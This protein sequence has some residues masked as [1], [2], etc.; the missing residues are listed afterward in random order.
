MR[1]NLGLV[2]SALAAR[3]TDVWSTGTHGAGKPRRTMHRPSSTSPPAATFGITVGLLHRGP[4]R[5]LWWHLRPFLR[6]GTKRPYVPQRPLGTQPRTGG[7]ER[8]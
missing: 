4:P 3:V 1:L 8:L 7:L 5:S 2:N 6:R